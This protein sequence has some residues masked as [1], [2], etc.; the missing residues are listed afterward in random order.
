MSG[1]MVD[2]RVRGGR[3]DY[4]VHGGEKTS[5]LW[6]MCGRR[7]GHAI[8]VTHRVCFEREEEEQDGEDAKKSYSFYLHA[9]SIC[10]PALTLPPFHH[11]FRPSAS[12]YHNLINFF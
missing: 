4:L 9:P 1:E 12:T 5:V 2:G 11:L 10:H 8:A 6:R 3:L 7:Y